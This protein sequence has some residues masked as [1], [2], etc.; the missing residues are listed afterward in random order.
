MPA[1]TFSGGVD[2][3]TMY[4]IDVIPYQAFPPKA[5]NRIYHRMMLRESVLFDKLQRAERE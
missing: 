1:Y 4:A 2:N 3:D 5:S